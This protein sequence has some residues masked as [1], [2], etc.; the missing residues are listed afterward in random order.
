VLRRYS[1]P[2]FPSDSPKFFSLDIC[3]AQIFV[4]PLFRQIRP[5]FFSLD[6][7]A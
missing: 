2:H 4:A 1:S 6:I 7:A 5:K 3:A